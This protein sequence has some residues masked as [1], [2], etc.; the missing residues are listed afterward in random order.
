[1]QLNLLLLGQLHPHT[2]LPIT[3]YFQLL[4]YESF[5]T[6]TLICPLTYPIDWTCAV[7]DVVASGCNAVKKVK[8]SRKRIMIVTELPVGSK[9]N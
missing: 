9:M 3:A 2:D 8:N 6:T 1:M 4:T 7:V 5:M